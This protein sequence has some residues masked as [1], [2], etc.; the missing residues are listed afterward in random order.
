MR[1][2]PQFL[3]L[4]PPSN[5]PPPKAFSSKRA[6][7]IQGGGSP[8]REKGGAPS[9]KPSSWDFLETP[10]RGSVDKNPAPPN[11]SL[12]LDREKKAPLRW[13]CLLFENLWGFPARAQKL[14]RFFHLRQNIA[15]AIAENRGTWRTQVLSYFAGRKGISKNLPSQV[16]G[17]IWVNFFVWFITKALDFMCR[18][19]ESFRKFLGSILRRFSSVLSL[20]GCSKEKGFQE[21]SIS[22]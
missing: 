15:I 19:P 4:K 12:P 21:T 11:P 13:K 8:R 18:R 9:G 5:P 2:P 1:A 7:F 16:F 10:L 17:K 22:F 6:F 14:L 3:R 20:E